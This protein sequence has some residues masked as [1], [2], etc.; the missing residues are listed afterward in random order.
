MVVKNCS[1]KT[2]SETFGLSFAR[3]VNFGVDLRFISYL[4]CMN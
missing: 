2:I 1:S 4:S 3:M